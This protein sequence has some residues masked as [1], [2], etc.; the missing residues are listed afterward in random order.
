M[1]EKNLRKKVSPARADSAVLLPTATVSKLQLPSKSVATR[2]SIC[3]AAYIRAD[4]AAAA[5]H[6]LCNDAACASA[7]SSER[8]GPCCLRQL[9]IV[10][11]LSLLD[12]FWLYPYLPKM[13]QINAICPRWLIIFHEWI[14]R[15]VETHMPTRWQFL[16]NWSIIWSRWLLDS[17]A[18]GVEQDPLVCHKWPL[19]SN[20]DTKI[21]TTTSFF[22]DYTLTYMHPSIHGGSN[23]ML[24]I[25]H[26]FSYLRLY[27]SRSTYS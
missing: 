27:V 24:S 22:M 1:V 21:N 12:P 15:S 16:T 2:W 23:A 9:R 5:E 10:G 4:T 20:L 8:T 6:V 17:Y 11:L 19:K 26:I 7:G 3:L 25:W 13:A 18:L 14:N